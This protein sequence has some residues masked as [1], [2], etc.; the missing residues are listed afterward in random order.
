MKARNRS[1]PRLRSHSRRWR[2][3]RELVPRSA[4]R[5]ANCVSILCRVRRFSWLRERRLRTSLS[6]RKRMPVTTLAKATFSHRLAARRSKV[7]ADSCAAS[8]ERSSF[9]AE[10]QRSLPTFTKQRRARVA[11][12]MH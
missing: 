5:I 1:H 4:R 9:K 3:P 6:K 7:R 12:R 8:Q 10:A 2:A 11:M